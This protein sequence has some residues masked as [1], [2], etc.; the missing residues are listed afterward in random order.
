MCLGGKGFNTVL[1]EG[2]QGVLTVYE[3]GGTIFAL[4]QALATRTMPLSV[5]IVY[6]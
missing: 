5:C 2:T 3:I 6:S 4:S 1:V